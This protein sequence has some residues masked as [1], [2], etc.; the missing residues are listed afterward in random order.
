MNNRKLCIG[1]FVIVCIVL[2]ILVILYIKWTK[3]PEQ[4]QDLPV[5]DGQYQPFIFAG[6]HEIY[7]YIISSTLI[8]HVNNQIQLTSKPVD[9]MS[10][11]QD[12]TTQD[13][14]TDVI[15]F[16]S[17]PR[18]Y[19][20]I[21]QN[22]PDKVH[23]V[24]TK[25]KKSNNLIQLYNKQIT[26]RELPDADINKSVDVGSADEL[27]SA[28][29][30]TR[31]SITDEQYDTVM[32]LVNKY[33]FNSVSLDFD[34]YLPDIR[35]YIQYMLSTNPGFM[36]N[37]VLTDAELEKLGITRENVTPPNAGISMTLNQ[38]I[39]KF[40]TGSETNTSTTEALFTTLLNN[41]EVIP[42]IDDAVR[43]T[44]MKESTQSMERSIQAYLFKNKI[45]ATNISMDRVALFK[46]SIINS[47]QTNIFYLLK[48]SSAFGS[49]QNELS[50]KELESKFSKL[51]T[52]DLSPEKLAKYAAMY[53]TDPKQKIHYNPD[54]ECFVLITKFQ[55]LRVVLKRK[56][57]ELNM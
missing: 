30:Q 37:I 27:N 5:S 32:K 33:S 17:I 42:V 46:M 18:I 44:L 3:S 1:L 56:E 13:T 41:K 16:A 51:F 29:E 40:I 4:F 43:E 38:G 2:V 45:M 24:F 57:I 19:V 7:D 34:S 48:D 14:T 26:G 22:M 49:A 10:T 21:S 20:Y 55:L 6:Y 47:Y 52:P 39:A 11:T 28:G 31:N 35:L 15:A 9:N 50:N 23:L 54:L 25:L 8:K 36:Y 53:K 12:T